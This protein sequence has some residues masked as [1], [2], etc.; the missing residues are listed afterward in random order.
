MPQTYPT[1]R[2][3]TVQ[4]T[5]TAAN[6]NSVSLEFEYLPE[7][8][9]FS[10]SANFEKHP[11]PLTS[12]RFV[13][14][15]Y[16]DIDDIQLSVKVVAG[17]NNAIVN[18]SA[19]SGKTW[20]LFGTTQAAK[21][22]RNDLITIAQYLYALALPPSNNP[23][24]GSI[25]PTCNLTIGPY[26]RVMGYVQSVGI[27]YSG[28]YDWDGSPT[29]MDVDLNFC[30]TEFTAFNDPGQ[31]PGGTTT[32]NMQ[33]L[34]TMDGNR[35]VS[36]TVESGDV[37]YAIWVGQNTNDYAATPPPAAPA[38]PSP[39]ASAILSGE[40]VQSQAQRDAGLTSGPA[41]SQSVTQKS[42]TYTNANIAEAYGL[43]VDLTNQDQVN[44]QVRRF[45][46]E[47]PTTHQPTGP[48]FYDIGS[49]KN[50]PEAVVNDNVQRYEAA[51]GGL[52]TSTT[53]TIP[54]K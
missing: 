53:T 1:I 17:C 39:S 24:G 2:I 50:V 43:P 51:H 7:S 11:L 41:T 44:N 37:P 40:G 38:N 47:D 20:A 33:A 12:A 48:F 54:L 8:M 3:S 19:A 45:Q 36:S 14:Y 52:T 27:K 4:N 30:P 10:V 46:N 28:P 25:P 15:N 42:G 26:C 32:P 13:I 18:Y 21:K 5:G 22:T 31:V 29:E 6:K 23:G 9:S 35:E 16:T 34:Q 49:M